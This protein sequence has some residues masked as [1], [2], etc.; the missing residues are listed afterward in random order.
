MNKEN[1]TFA[2]I[3]LACELSQ[4]L[5]SELSEYYWGGIVEVFID[6]EEQA[7]APE[8]LYPFG[9]ESIMNRVAPVQVTNG[10]DPRPTLFDELL[11]EGEN[12]RF[13]CGGKEDIPNIIFIEHPNK[14]DSTEK[15]IS[16]NLM[17]D[18]RQFNKIL[19][20]TI[21]LCSQGNNG[22]LFI[23]GWGFSYEDKQLSDEVRDFLVDSGFQFTSRHH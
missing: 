6:C 20:S 1:R 22:L 9:W 12:P 13:T 23:G 16:L 14:K 8:D 15:L 11:K 19:N 7:L 18:K 17:R 4:E 21:Q 3:L 5:K 2:Y 10:W